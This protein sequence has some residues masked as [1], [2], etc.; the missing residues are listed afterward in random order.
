[1]RENAPRTRR[2]GHP[3]AACGRWN[4]VDRE[5]GRP[6]LDM[7]FATEDEA[8]AFRAD[9]LLPYPFRSEWRRRIGV[10]AVR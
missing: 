6:Y 1:M 8:Y 7:G 10:E 2:L 3:T 5:T 9:L 4:V